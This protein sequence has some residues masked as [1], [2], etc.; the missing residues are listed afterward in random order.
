M[1]NENDEKSKVIGLG[2]KNI[3]SKSKDRKDYIT[4]NIANLA[5]KKE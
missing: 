4:A 3:L 2:D 1:V 5:K